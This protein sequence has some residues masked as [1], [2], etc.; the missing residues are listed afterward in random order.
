MSNVCKTI[1]ATAVA[2]F[3]IAHTSNAQS[4]FDGYEIGISAG[5]LIYQGDLTPKP[6]GYLK[7]IKP[8][9]GI[10]VSKPLG[11]Y[12]SVRL[13]F[14]RGRILADDAA[15]T[16]PA[17]KQQRNFEFTSSVTELT[18]T[19]VFNPFGRLSES[20]F[21]RFS[22]YVFAGA[23]L[24]F[25]NIK[26]NWS[27]LNTAA[28]DAKSDVIVGLGTDTLTTLP[29]VLPVIPLG[30]GI[31]YNINNNW[32]IFAEAAYRFTAS[33]YLD[34]FKYAANKD[35]KDSYYGLSL[36]LSYTFGSSRYNCPVIK[37]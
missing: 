31:K 24:S 22:P 1:V 19:V 8:A 36:G 18:G 7:T 34:G 11:D 29:K 4:K 5:T 27:G 3:F 21:R 10:Y 2:L 12:F 32:S 14:E 28:F 13:N 6:Y 15:Y 33:D 16:E 30:A 37:P 26:R 25:V 17:W 23:G 35:R 9:F 20:N